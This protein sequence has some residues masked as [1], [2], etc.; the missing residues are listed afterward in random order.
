MTLNKDINE[1]VVTDK[2]K[3]FTIMSYDDNF[4]EEFTIDET[5]LN[6]DTEL[7]KLAYRNEIV[8]SLDTRLFL[9]CT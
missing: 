5:T 3:S 7:L 2:Q 4:D 6:S 8:S 1:R 9:D